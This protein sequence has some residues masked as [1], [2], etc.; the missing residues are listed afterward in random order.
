MNGTKFCTGCKKDLPQDAFGTNLHLPG[1]LDYHC[2]ACRRT[3]ANQRTRAL[4][5]DPVLGP[6]LRAKWVARHANPEYRA[7]ARAARNAKYRAKKAAA[8]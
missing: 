8:A 2:L 1:G 4:L 3:S 6:A 5:A 7:Y